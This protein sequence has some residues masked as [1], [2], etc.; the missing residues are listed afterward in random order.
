MPEPLGVLGVV[1]PDG[2]PLLGF[3][4]TVLPLVAMGN[5]VVAIPP[6]GAPLAATDLY[7]VLDTSDLPGAW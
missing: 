2:W 1:C 3:V 6:T 5:S 7:Q 4:S